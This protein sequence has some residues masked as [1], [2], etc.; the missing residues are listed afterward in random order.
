MIAE[1]NKVVSL[2]YRLTENDVD[3]TL[4]EEVNENQPFTFLFG[5]GNLIPG[6]EQNVGNLKVGDN[7]AFSV[8]AAEAYGELDEEGIVEL[9][10]SVF[11]QDGVMDD[12]VI[13]VGNVLPMQDENGHHFNGIIKSIS[14]TSITMD[15]NHPLAGVNLHFKGS[16]VGIREATEQELEHGHIHQDHGHEEGHSCG[17][18]CD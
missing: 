9:P 17:C 6:F 13:K 14:E 2:T 5:A 12:E 11:Q 8:T 1:K 18:G 16:V 4:I 10:L 7:F 3:G 15:F